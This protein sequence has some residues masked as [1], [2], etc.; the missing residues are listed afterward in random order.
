MRLICPNCDAQ[1]DIADDVIPKGGRDVQCSSCTHTWFQTDKSAAASPKRSILTPTPATIPEP[2]AE[3]T[4]ATPNRNTPPQRKPLD[5]SI[6]D[7]LRQE[8]GRGVPSPSPVRAPTPTLGA[9]KSRSRPLS[10]DASQDTMTHE[11]PRPATGRVASRPVENSEER[12][13]ETLRRI[14]RL[15]GD[16]E[17]ARTAAQ[18]VEAAKPQEAGN[19]RSMPGIDE[20]NATLRARLEA[21]EASGM[22]AAEQQQVVQ[23]RGFRRGFAIV[24]VLIGLM[25]APYFFTEEIVAYVPQAR[26]Y[27]AQYIETVDQLRVQ[28]RDVAAQVRILVQDL[29][30]PD[31]APVSDPSAEQSPAAPTT[32]PATPAD[33]V[34]TAPVAQTDG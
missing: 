30:P 31:T 27:M 16:A 12:A 25:I 22:T 3:D 11:T 28:L 6:A 18:P 9:G 20:I 29:M 13:A 23:R 26:P 14:S 10:R 15:T 19:R 1:Y 33:P 32:A 34:V 2:R 24:L 17:S 8:A 5:N 7:I 4:A 21:N